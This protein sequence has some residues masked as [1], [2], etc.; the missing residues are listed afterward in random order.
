MIATFHPAAQLPAAPL[1]SAVVTTDDTS[2]QLKSVSM[3]AEG[4]LIDV[5]LILATEIRI[6][7]SRML[8]YLMTEGT[9]HEGKKTVEGRES[10][11]SR[12]L[13]AFSRR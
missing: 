10:L 11:L 1:L 12:S 7:I 4:R 5:R 13:Q 8:R 2:S 6:D 9:G 3:M